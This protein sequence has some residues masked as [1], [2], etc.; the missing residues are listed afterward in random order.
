MYLPSVWYHPPHIALYTLYLLAITFWEFECVVNS[1]HMW[2]QSFPRIRLLHFV[3]APHLPERTFCYLY[4]KKNPINQQVQQRSVIHCGL[5]QHSFLQWF[6]SLTACSNLNTIIFYKLRYQRVYSAWYHAISCS[7]PRTLLLYWI[8][9]QSTIVPLFLCYTERNVNQCILNRVRVTVRVECH[10]KWHWFT[11]RSVW[12]SC[13]GTWFNRLITSMDMSTI[14]RD[15]RL[16][17]HV[18]S[19]IYQ[20]LC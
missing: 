10:S 2:P 16:D 3:W 14:S 7:C 6:L 1:F 5:V 20:Q 18:D 8:V 11:F 12:Q 4:M 13:S 9:S 17:R 15:T 19:V